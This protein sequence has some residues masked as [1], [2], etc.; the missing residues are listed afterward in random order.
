MVVRGGKGQKDRAV[1]VADRLVRH[2]AAQRIRARTRFD[3]D[4]A[5]GLG[6]VSLPFALARKYPAAPVEWAWFWLFPAEEF[7]TDPYSGTPVRHDQEL[8]RMQQAFES[9]L[10]KTSIE[11]PASPHT[12]RHSFATH[13]LQAGSGTISPMDRSLE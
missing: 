1:M 12:L 10:R 2:L 11:K 5:A 7:C 6:G 13:L 3:A 4:R 8:S 9:A